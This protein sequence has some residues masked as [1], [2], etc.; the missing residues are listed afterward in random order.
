M[1]ARN[2]M[3]KIQIFGATSAMAI[4]AINN[5]ERKKMLECR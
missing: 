2:I 4:S 1:H 3:A 5:D